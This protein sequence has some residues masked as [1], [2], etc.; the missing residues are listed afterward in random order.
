MKELRHTQSQPSILLPMCFL[1]TVSKS[2]NAWQTQTVH[3]SSTVCYMRF[4]LSPT[5]SSGL[6]V[7]RAQ[8]GKGVEDH[9]G[10]QGYMPRP[11]DARQRGPRSRGKEL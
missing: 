4:L 1:L 5:Q 3:P 10:S 9:V 7:R 11:W 6:R 8:G 2:T